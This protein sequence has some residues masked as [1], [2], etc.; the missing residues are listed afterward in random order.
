MSPRRILPTAVLTALLLAA[1]A[2]ARP[3]PADPPSISAHPRTEVRHRFPWEE[4]A[5][6]VGAAAVA[7]S[8]LGRRRR[9]AA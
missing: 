6:V 3:L 4:T 7:A 5:A 2:H 8:L 1:P 9:A